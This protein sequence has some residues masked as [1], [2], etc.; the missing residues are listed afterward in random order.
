MINS[1]I[2][3]E[4]IRLLPRA[5]HIAAVCALVTIK[6]SDHNSRSLR[7]NVPSTKPRGHAELVAWYRSAADIVSRWNIYSVSFNDVDPT[8]AC[9]VS[10][11]ALSVSFLHNIKV[12]AY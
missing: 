4:R 9:M 12:E 6:I 1:L 2:R 11:A 10:T 3:H 8:R 5:N 7:P